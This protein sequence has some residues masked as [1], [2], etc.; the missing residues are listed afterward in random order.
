VLL[1]SDKRV[2]VSGFKL[3]SHFSRNAKKNSECER[4]VIHFRK[5]AQRNSFLSPIIFSLVRH[6]YTKEKK[7]NLSAVWIRSFSL[8]P[9]TSERDND[10][11]GRVVAGLLPSPCI[12]LF[13]SR[14]IRGRGKQSR[15]GNQEGTGE[16]STKHE[17]K[18]TINKETF[19]PC[20]F[21]SLLLLFFSSN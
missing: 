17:Y 2:Y 8:S 18:R 3:R 1:E 13:L 9:L 15:P 10:D 4:S 16:G 5:S 11:R 21:H 14:K 6:I 19:G 7:K 12:F 20:A